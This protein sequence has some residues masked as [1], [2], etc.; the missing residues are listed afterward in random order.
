MDISAS[1]PMAGDE[2]IP[3]SMGI[4]MRVG[5]P[6]DYLQTPWKLSRDALK[7]RE[8]LYMSLQVSDAVRYLSGDEESFGYLKYFTT[9]CPVD[10]TGGYF[11]LG[12]CFN[13]YLPQPLLEKFPNIEDVKFKYNDYGP[14]PS[15]S[16]TWPVP[17]FMGPT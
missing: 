1:Y 10:T 8:D 17:P 4:S 2:H 12:N 11:E 3:G 9:P 7:I 16:E 5:L 14:R 6:G 15:W 13:G